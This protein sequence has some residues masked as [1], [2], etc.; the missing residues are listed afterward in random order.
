MLGKSVDSELKAKDD[1]KGGFADILRKNNFK[2]ILELILNRNW[3][4]HFYAVQVLYYAFVDIVDS[5][6]RFNDNPMLFKSLLYEVLK[7]DPIRTI[8][9]FKQY[10]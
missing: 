1:L 2:Q 5:I 6:D 9:H 7:T 10:K 8:N 3:H 4:I